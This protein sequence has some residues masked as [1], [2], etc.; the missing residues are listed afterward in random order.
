MIEILECPACNGKSFSPFLKTKD[1]TTTGEEFTI[2][3]CTQCLLLI[4]SPRPETQHLAKYYLSKDYISHASGAKSLFDNLYLLAR[5]FTHSWKAAILKEIS[6]NK[7]IL[8]YGC[9]TG[10][11]LIY[12][13]NNGWNATGI[14]PSPDARRIAEAS[15]NGGIY[16]SIDDVNEKYELITLWHVLEHIPDLGQTISKL[17]SHLTPKGKL[18]IAVPNPTSWESSKYGANWAA[19]DVPRHLWHFNQTSIN[20][21]FRKMGFKLVNTIPMKLDSLYISILSAKYSRGRKLGILNFLSG[22]TTGIVS[23]L[24]ARKTGEYSS[25]IYIFTNEEN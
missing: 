3:K 21:L 16:E 1:Y 17:K 7:Q 4:T 11:L 24:N 19:Y 18:L 22:I 15:A 8:D 13:R 14:E 23:N 6:P 5:K 25:L 20:L 10:S 12:L 9:G 2:V